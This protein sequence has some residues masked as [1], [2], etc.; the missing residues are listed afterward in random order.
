M[1]RF[2]TM[3]ARTARDLDRVALTVLGAV[4][5]VA[6]GPA[7]DVIA[8]DKDAF[9]VQLAVPGFRQDELE[10]TAEQGVLTITGKPVAATNADQVRYLQRGIM[11]RPFARR[12]RLDEHVEVVDAHLADGILKVA[13]ERRVPEALRPRAIAISGPQA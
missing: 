8:V 3:L 2:D 4:E 11:R 1:T 7:Y 12:F 13:L 10:V 9:A 6:G 5:P